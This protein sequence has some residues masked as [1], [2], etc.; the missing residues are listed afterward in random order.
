M[1][2]NRKKEDTSGRKYSRQL[3]SFI[4]TYVFQLVSLWQWERDCF[5][6]TYLGSW[7]FS[8]LP[9]CCGFISI[10]SSP[11]PLGS[12]QFSFL[13]LKEEN[14]IPQSRITETCLS[15]V[16]FSKELPF[17]LITQKLAVVNVILQSRAVFQCSEVH[18]TREHTGWVLLSFA[19]WLPLTS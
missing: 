12:G 18:V 15:K 5:S 7:F 3:H 4:G 10:L 1:L 9:G 16:L 2:K 14:L 17:A 11:F 6:L 8:L 13:W 19:L